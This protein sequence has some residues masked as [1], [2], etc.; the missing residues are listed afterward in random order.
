MLEK[1]SFHSL[2]I[3]FKK[4]KHTKERIHVYGVR[5]RRTTSYLRSIPD[6]DCWLQTHDSE[7]SG[8]AETKTQEA[9][10]NDGTTTA[11]H[12]FLASCSRFKPK[13]SATAFATHKSNVVDISQGAVKYHSKTCIIVRSQN[14]VQSLN[15]SYNR[16]LLYVGHHAVSANKLAKHPWVSLGLGMY[17]GSHLQVGG[18]R[19][20]ESLPS[21]FTL[22]RQ[23][24]NTPGHVCLLPLYQ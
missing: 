18:P 7:R 19:N 13:P 15:C 17:Q 6:D 1:G 20:D 8:S 21:T 12:N 11:L 4:L 5:T 23:S 14:P 24:C 9:E 10:R 22:R 2:A 16:Y 3:G